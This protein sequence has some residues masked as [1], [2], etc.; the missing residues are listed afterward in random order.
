MQYLILRYNVSNL[1]FQNKCRTIACRG[2]LVYQN[3]R[4]EDMYISVSNINFNFTL[5]YLYIGDTGKTDDLEA[6]VLGMMRQDLWINHHF[7]PLHGSQ[8]AF[9]HLGNTDESPCAYITVN[10]SL[11]GYSFKKIDNEIIE[12]FEDMYTI[13]KPKAYMMPQ[14]VS[15]ERSTTDNSCSSCVLR[16]SNVSC[17]FISKIIPSIE[18]SFFYISDNYTCPYIAL[19]QQELDSLKR[20]NIISSNAHFT[21]RSN[22]YLVCIKD[23]R[24]DSVTQKAPTCLIEHFLLCGCLIGSILSTVS[25]LV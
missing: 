8:K 16:N 12:F 21:R 22:G 5:V 7:I 10:F 23:V 24:F 13:T 4:C 3:G 18:K 20:R 15:L 25:V 11:H 17:F 1:L 2:R 6:M 14:N 19:S 9:A